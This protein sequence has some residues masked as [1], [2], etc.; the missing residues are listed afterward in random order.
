VAAAALRLARTRDIEEGWAMLIR[1][2]DRALS[3]I[4]EFP[5]LAEQLIRLTLI[6]DEASRGIGI[7]ADNK[8]DQGVQFSKF[9]SIAD[10]ALVENELRSF[11]WDVP[12]EALC[13]LGKLRTSAGIQTSSQPWE[14]MKR[15]LR[16]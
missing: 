7:G 10:H 6:A 14:L 1:E 5:E 15:I 16:S 4:D 3:A 13:V 12:P 8:T 11:C 2:R 9:L